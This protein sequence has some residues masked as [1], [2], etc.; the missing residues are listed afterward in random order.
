[1]TFW[2]SPTARYDKVADVFWGEIGV[3]GPGLLPVVLPAMRLP[4]VA[5]VLTLGLPVLTSACAHTTIPGTEIED[6]EENRAIIRVVEEYKTA[7]EAMDTDAILALVSPN[8]YEN[9]GNIDESDDYDKVGLGKNLRSNFE[10]T[11]RIQLILRID[12][13]LVEEQTAY[14][15]LYYQIRAHNEYPAGL[16]WE[17]GSDR[18]RL[19]FERVEDRWLIVAGL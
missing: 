12:D 2:H 13:V 9:N 18:T 14:A 16:K 6:T 3:D 19:T 5:L 4:G 7:V 11:K 1:M 15:E 17:T 10:R 8:F